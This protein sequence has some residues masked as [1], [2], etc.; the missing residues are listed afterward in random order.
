MAAVNK[1][2]MGGVAGALWTIKGNAS[3]PHM[4]W[5]G[6]VSVCRARGDVV[7]DRVQSGDV[8]VKTERRK[9]LRG[10]GWVGGG[11][12]VGTGR[13]RLCVSVKRESA[14]EGLGSEGVCERTAKRRREAEPLW[15]AEMDAAPAPC[16]RT[17]HSVLGASS[18]FPSPVDHPVTLLC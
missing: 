15:V 10:S 12:G 11:K 4:V 2:E 8:C 7:Q 6:R 1:R 18:A 16:C 9:Y 13:K 5:R 17:E 3:A 14:Q